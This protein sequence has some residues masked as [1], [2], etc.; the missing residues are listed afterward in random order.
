[1]DEFHFDFNAVLF[2]WRWKLGGR[3]GWGMG[4]KQEKNYFFPD[5]NVFIEPPLE[6]RKKKTKRGSSCEWR[7]L[8]AVVQRHRFCEFV[9]CSACGYFFCI[10]GEL[11]KD[12]LK[13]MTERRC[14]SRLASE[15]GRMDVLQLCLPPTLTQRR[16]A[17]GNLN[18]GA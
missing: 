17:V 10:C 8:R 16:F 5:M 13:V 18:I 9:S 1:M 11:C 12:L 14:L 3:G 2:E 15:P 6:W 4:V 7:S